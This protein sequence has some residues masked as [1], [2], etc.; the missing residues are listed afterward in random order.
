M[1]S[2][3]PANPEAFSVTRIQWRSFL[4]RFS[5]GK[6]VHDL[7]DRNVCV[8]THVCLL[9]Q[10]AFVRGDSTFTLLTIEDQALCTLV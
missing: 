9:E 5:P 10:R 8:L 7:F 4:S 1:W 6:L 3:C 2:I